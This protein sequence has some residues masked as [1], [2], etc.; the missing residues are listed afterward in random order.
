MDEPGRG[1][2][3]FR[4]AMWFE[5]LCV[6]DA[7]GRP[8]GGSRLALRGEMERQRTPQETVAKVPLQASGNARERHGK[9]V[10]LGSHAFL[11]QSP[12]QPDP[13][14]SEGARPKTILNH[15]TSSAP[16]RQSTRINAQHHLKIT[17]LLVPVKVSLW[18]SMV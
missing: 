17:S 5:E 9:G 3:L 8:K 12:Q 6:R 2:A 4:K 18:T 7:E 1:V 13:E 16:A 11:Q 15:A 14:Q 10:G